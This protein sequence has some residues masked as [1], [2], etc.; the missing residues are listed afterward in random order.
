MKTDIHPTYF[1][2]ANVTCACGNAFKVGSTKE[3]INVE[4]CSQCHPFYTGTEKSLDAAGRVEKF[5]ARAAA[6]KP[7]KKAAAK[8]A[9]KAEAPAVEKAEKSDK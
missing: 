6:A 7:A 3:K 9:D 8:T 1:V 5:K 4:I 2:D